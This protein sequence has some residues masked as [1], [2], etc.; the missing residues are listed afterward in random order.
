MRSGCQASPK[1]GRPRRLRFRWITFEGT[2]EYKGE[3]ME[4]YIQDLGVFE[5]SRIHKEIGS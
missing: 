2:E 4:V 5:A 3:Q 1:L